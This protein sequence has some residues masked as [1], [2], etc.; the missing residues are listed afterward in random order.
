MSRR[1][2]VTFYFFCGT[3]EQAD[4]WFIFWLS[5]GYFPP[6]PPASP[7]SLPSKRHTECRWTGISIWIWHRAS[8]IF[9]CA[10]WRV[11]NAR[12]EFVVNA[13]SFVF[14]RRSTFIWTARPP[15][16]SVTWCSVC[17]AARSFAANKNV[18]RAH[19]RAAL[20]HAR[21]ESN[22]PINFRSE[23]SYVHFHEIHGRT[24]RLGRMHAVPF[25]I[26]LHKMCV[27]AWMW[28]WSTE[29]AQT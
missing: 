18:R 11:K 13:L 16:V 29:H 12:S 24:V 2:D 10:R 26:A 22:G 27:C 6:P 19:G 4:E 14:W 21:Y 20:T 15:K 8:D 5:F 17:A 3:S 25:E 23:K 28:M 9:K 7:P 1:E